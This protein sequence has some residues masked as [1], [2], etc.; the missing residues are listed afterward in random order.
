MEC[1]CMN[2]LCTKLPKH[3]LVLNKKSKTA[4]W[5]TAT[6]ESEISDH[7]RRILKKINRLD[8]ETS[9]SNNLERTSVRSIIAG[10][11]QRQLSSKPSYTAQGHI[12]AS[13]CI[14]LNLNLKCIS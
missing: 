14:L 4:N 10:Y 1:N 5:T 2:L 7:D 11:Q 9:C 8:G 13:S 3:K 12:Q 6:R